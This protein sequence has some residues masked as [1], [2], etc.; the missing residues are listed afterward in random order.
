MK[1]LTALLLLA[2]LVSPLAADTILLRNGREIEGRVLSETDEFVRLE[3]SGTITRLRRDTIAQ[4]FRAP[5]W[6]NTLLDAETAFKRGDAVG[7]IDLIFRSQREGAPRHHLA[8][9]LDDQNPRLMGAITDANSEETLGIRRSI[10]ALLSEDLVTTGGLYLQARNLHDLGDWE[11]SAALLDRLPLEAVSENAPRRRW[12]LEFFRDFVKRELSRGEFENALVFI[13]KMRRLQGATEAPEIPVVQLAA[14]AEARERGDYP[15]ALRILV[16]ELHPVVP[17]IARNRVI[18][19]LG[20]LIEEAGETGGYTEAREALEIIADTFPVEHANARS[21]LYLEEGKDLLLR[22]Q[23]LAALAVLEG[24]PAEE[25]NDELGQT[26]RRA[27]HEARLQSIGPNNPLALLEHGRWCADNGMLLEAIEIFE[28]T[29]RNPNLRDISE[30]LITLTERERDLGL[31][32]AAQQAYDEGVFSRVLDSTRPLLMNRQR[33]SSFANEA[34]R[35]ENLARLELNREVES[36]G[37]R[38][39]VAFQN[40]E[41]AFFRQEHE[42]ALHHLNDILRN[43]AD[44]PAAGWAADLLPDVVRALEISYLEGR[45]ARIP[46][47]ASSFRLDQIQETDALGDE[48]A[49]LLSGLDEEEEPAER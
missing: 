22:G 25:R 43:Y 18:H 41:R 31:I 2:I 23:P 8:R 36:R 27:Y 12:A 7:A 48:V 29:R 17:G 4:I 11:T 1:S 42:L 34:N 6:E 28:R 33:P 46:P 47:V 26:Y 10:R 19:T 21:R 37:P 35:L 30:E 40:A 20:F 15:L 14:S 32:R 3:I 5:E 38:A 45:I 49:R 9:F 44:T 13:E 39:V 24:I 16:E